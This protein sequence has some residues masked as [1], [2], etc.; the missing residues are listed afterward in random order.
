MEGTMKP[1]NF[2]ARRRA[3]LEGALSRMLA[4][5]PK[6][7]LQSVL[8]FPEARAMA[9]REHAEQV[10]VWERDVAATKA[11]LA[12]CG[13]RDTRTKKDR[14]ARGRLSRAA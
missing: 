1:A 2:P 6:P 12:A 3:R 13:N 10:A 9:A 4:S 14:S 5:K 11:A 8:E 7:R